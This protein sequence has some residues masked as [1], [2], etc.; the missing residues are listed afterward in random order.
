MFSFLTVVNRGSRKRLQ[1]TK[2]QEDSGRAKISRLEEPFDQVVFTNDEEEG[3]CHLLTR[4]Q[5]ANRFSVLKTAFASSPPDEDEHPSSLERMI[6]ELMLLETTMPDFDDRMKDSIVETGAA[7]VPTTAEFLGEHP[8]PSDVL[9]VRQNDRFDEFVICKTAAEDEMFS[10]DL[11]FGPI[12]YPDECDSPLCRIQEGHVLETIRNFEV[13][14]Q[15]ET[16]KTMLPASAS[17]SAHPPLCQPGKFVR[18][19]CWWSEGNA[20]SRQSHGHV[21]CTDD[22]RWKTVSND[23][24]LVKLQL[25]STE[26][27]SKPDGKDFV[28]DHDYC[29]NLCELTMREGAL[30][31]TGDERSS[32]DAKDMRFSQII[33]NYSSI[34]S[35][36]LDSNLAEEVRKEVEL[37]RARSREN[38]SE[39]L[40]AT[41]ASD[42]RLLG[43]VRDDEKSNVSKQL[44]TGCNHY[45]PPKSNG[46]LCG[47]NTV[48]LEND[49]IVTGEENTVQF[50]ERF[51]REERRSRLECVLGDRKLAATRSQDGICHRLGGFET[52]PSS[53]EAAAAA[54][55][56][57][58]DSGI[59]SSA[60]PT[61][62]ELSANSDEAVFFDSF[63]EFYR[64]SQVGGF[65]LLPDY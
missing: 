15:T 22:E 40:R 29:Q 48:T 10:S 62:L 54:G 20:R 65:D 36:L 8:P 51:R 49:Y 39:K 2:E 58:S 3:G 27:H 63:D 21:C 6:T 11:E 5:D 64:N 41:S 17:F 46:H 59:D 44:A 61:D 7:S 30:D 45:S 16:E 32:C 18:Q 12:F 23:D 26:C 53:P 34:K 42:T 9:V 35:L 57:G 13:P 24:L 31:L 50:N 47:K 4:E 28:F 56:I 1:E 14:L 38:M 37:E 25:H 19:T 33:G 60:S 52:S 43:N 55:S